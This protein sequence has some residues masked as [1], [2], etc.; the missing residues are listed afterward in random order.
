MNG[1]T[2][3]NSKSG[4][5]TTPPLEG[6]GEASNIT[7]PYERM[8]RL[9]IQKDTK[10]LGAMLSDDFELVHMTGMHQPKAV[11]L[12]TSYEPQVTAERSEG[13]K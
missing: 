1:N 9:M 4:Y 6:L 3:D 5:Q 2:S 7:M 13:Q 11:Y 12:T 8:Y 10:A